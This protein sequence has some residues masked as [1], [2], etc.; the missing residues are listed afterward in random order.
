MPTPEPRA[1]AYAAHQAPPAVA[2]ATAPAGPP[3]GPPPRPA[4][5]ALPKVGPQGPGAGVTGAVLGVCLIVAAGVLIATRSFGY[6]GPTFL[7][8]GA[9]SLIVIGLAVLIAGIRGRTSGGLGGLAVLGFVLLLPVAAV[10]SWTGSNLLTGGTALGELTAQPLTAADAER[11]FSLG[12][13][14]LEVDLTGMSLGDDLIEVPVAVGDGEAVVILPHDGAWTA[15]VQVM[16]GE[17]IDRGRQVQSGVLPG[18]ALR[19]ESHAVG[20]GAEPDLDLRI[21]VGAGTVELKEAT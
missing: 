4:S 19:S 10:H 16:V 9:L 8:F 6:D 7:T 13:G 1:T 17:V 14:E 20:E 5:T 21:G 15:E 3:V 12:A 18:D 11:G 2:Y